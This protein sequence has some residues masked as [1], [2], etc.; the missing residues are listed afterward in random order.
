M[1][2]FVV[3]SVSSLP[4]PTPPQ[5]NPATPPPR[6]VN[7]CSGE[8]PQWTLAQ[9]QPVK[10][11]F[12]QTCLVKDTSVHVLCYDCSERSQTAFHFLGLE[13]KQCGSFNT[14]RI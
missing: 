8:L 4:T 11:T 3:H 2:P 1:G 6:P 9:E 14:S 7:L 13:C 5:Q 12:L 10:A